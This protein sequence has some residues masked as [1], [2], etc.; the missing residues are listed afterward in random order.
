MR[1]PEGTDGHDYKFRQRV[2]DRYKQ[3]ATLRTKILPHIVTL[4]VVYHFLVVGWSLSPFLLSDAS[5]VEHRRLVLAAVGMLAVLLGNNGLRP[6]ASRHSLVVY[7][8]LCLSLT[9][10]SIFSYRK[11]DAGSLALARLTSLFFRSSRAAHLV[12][13][14]HIHN[15]I[16]MFGLLLHVAA[17]ALALQ[18]WGLL[19]ISGKKQE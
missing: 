12:I 16:F 14:Q 3:I 6:K 7:G 2:D 10:A 5:A 18:L 11:N 15:G 17:A 9:I 19:G 1:R 4:Q 8:M 13:A